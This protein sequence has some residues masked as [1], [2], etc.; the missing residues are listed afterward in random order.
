MRAL[1]RAAKLYIVALLLI[2]GFAI[3]ISIPLLPTT[4]SGLA[5]LGLFA[6]M[7]CLADLLPIVMLAGKGQ[8]VISTAIQIGSIIL[9]GPAFTVVATMLGTLAAEI[10]ERRVWYK[11]AF[12]VAQFVI[13]V[14]TAG[15]IYVG[16]AD[17]NPAH[18]N[19]LPDFM[20]FLAAGLVYY[21]MNNSLVAL[22]VALAE[23]IP[24]LT[25]WRAAFRDVAWHNL[26]MIPLG[27]MFAL[28]W[29]VQ[30]WS[31]VLAI[32]PIFVVRSSMGMVRQLRDQTKEALIALA[33]TIDARDPSTYQHSQRVAEYAEMIARQLRL[34]FDEVELL[35]TSARLHDLGKMGMDNV[36]LY[37]PG[38][39]SNEEWREFQRHSAIGESL[40]GK[41]P[42]FGAGRNLV[43]YHHEHFNGRGYPD[44]KKGEE[45]PLGAR[46]LAVADAYDAMISDRPYRPAMSKEKAIAELRAG[47]GTQFDPRVVEAFLTALTRREEERE[48]MPHRARPRLEEASSEAGKR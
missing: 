15:I 28:L 43:R 34:S 9:F 6:L 27:A 35:V 14:A 16:L 37:K 8:V 4:P 36:M 45:I 44:G 33:D 30:P 24:A 18:L 38:S 10:I 17:E 42:A 21:F 48:Y 47:S 41:F 25:V 22:A 19:S 26:V 7:L 40:V 12:N 1:P 23:R 31:V 11:A 32:L 46:I 13:A 20:A 5:T 39:F 2:A 29:Q 3:A